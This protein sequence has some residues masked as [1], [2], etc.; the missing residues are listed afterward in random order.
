[1]PQMPPK[2]TRRENRESAAASDVKRGPS[3]AERV[4]GIEK[5]GG[6]TGVRF[7]VHAHPDKSVVTK[8]K[9]KD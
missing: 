4:S 5:V 6:P 9:L 7:P 1:M 3:P 8:G 2:E